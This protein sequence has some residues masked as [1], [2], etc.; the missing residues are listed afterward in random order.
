VAVFAEDT[1]AA[2]A[3]AETPMEAPEISTE[4]DEP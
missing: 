3:P 2:T 4:G 1:R